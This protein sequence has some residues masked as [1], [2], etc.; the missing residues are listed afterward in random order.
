MKR[1]AIVGYSYRMPGS[2]RK[3]FWSQLLANKDLV[4]QVEPSRWSQETFLHPDKKHPGS[5][6]TFAAGSI[7]EVYGF[8]AGFFGLSPR[9]VNQMDPQQRLLLEMTWEAMESSGTPPSRMRGSDCGVY[10]GLASIDHAF[11]YTDDLNSVGANTATGGAASIAANR[12]SYLFDLHGPSMII[13]TACSSSM[14]AFHQAC[15]AIRSGEISSALTGGISLH[16]HPYGFLIFSKATMLSPNGRCKAFDASGDG[17]VRSE[18]GGVF[19]LKDYDLALE[20]GDPILAIVADTAVNTDG[21]KSGL[22]IPAAEAQERL[23]EQIYQRAG[24][25]PNRISYLEA[26]GTGTPVGDPIETRALGR[27]LAQKRN[28][29]LPIGSVKSNVGH[30]ETASGVAGLVK[31]L[32]VIQHRQLPATIGVEQINPNIHHQDWNLDIVRENRELSREDELIVG[33]NSFG[34]G[35]ANAHVILQSPP[36]PQ[37]KP[38]PS[39]DMGGVRPLRISARSDAALRQMADDL[40]DYLQENPDTDYYNLAWT[41]WFKREHHQKGFIVL[42]SGTDQAIAQLHSYTEQ[43][44]ALHHLTGTRLS[45]AKGMVFVYSGNG[46]QWETMGKQLL[47]ESDTF[48]AS[49]QKVDQL[50]QQYGDFSILAELTGD[51]GKERFT[52]TEVAQPALFALQVGITEYLIDA[53]IIPVAVVGH[54]VGEVA[55]AWTSGALTLND[56][57]KVIYHRSRC[58]GYTAGSGQMTAVALPAEELQL[59]LSELNLD[60]VWLAGINSPKGLTVAGRIEQLDHLEEHLKVHGVRFKRLDLDYPFH[61]P[62]MD[63]IREDLLTSLADIQPAATN[64]P[65]YSSVTGSQLEGTALS[66]G[67]WWENIRQPVIF[68]QALQQLFALEHNVFV[69][70]GGHPVL[71]AYIKEGLRVQEQEGLTIPTLQRNLDGEQQLKHCVAQVLLSGVPA[72]ETFWFPVAGQYLSIPGYP[73]QHQ[74]YRLPVTQEALGNLDRHSEHPLLGYRP[75]HNPETWEQQLDT[76]K[77]P[78]LADHRVG[79]GSVFPGA[80]YIELALAAASSARPNTVLEVEELEILSPML[81][82]DRPTKVARFSLDSDQGHFSYA[83]RELVNGTDWTQHF[84]GRMTNENSGLSLIR[85]VPPIPDRSPD[86]TLAEHL[87]LAR[88]IG[89]DYGEAFQAVSHGWVEDQKVLCVFNLPEALYNSQQGMLLAPGILDSVFQQF[90]QLLKTQIAEQPGVAFVPTQVGRVQ[91]A[92]AAANQPLSHACLQLTRHSPHSLLADVEIYTAQGQVLAILEAVRFKAIPLR[93]RKSHTLSH[94]QQSWTPAPLRHQYHAPEFSLPDWIEEIHTG[95][96][97]TEKGSLYA[98]EVEPLLDTLAETQ[99]Q[100]WLNKYAPKL[101]ENPLLAQKPLFSQLFALAQERGLQPEPLNSIQETPSSNEIWTLL[102]QDYPGWFSLTHRLGRQGLQLQTH[103]PEDILKDALHLDQTVYSQL[104]SKILG[105]DGLSAL[106]TSVIAKVQQLEAELKPG[107]RL[108][109]AELMISQPLCAQRLS[110]HLNYDLVDLTL[111]TASSQADN[112]ARS[113]QEHHHLVE[114]VAIDTETGEIKQSIKPIQL[115]LAHLDFIDLDQALQILR[116]IK[117]QL[118]AGAKVLLIGHHP[119]YWLDQLL[120]TSPEWRSQ[121]GRIQQ[122]TAEHWLHY[123]QDLGFEETQIRS[124]YP[125]N[126]VSFLLAGSQPILTEKR[127]PNQT[128]WLVVENDE[129]S[130]HDQLV[131]LLNKLEDQGCHIQT[132]PASFLLAHLKILAEE[133]PQYPLQLLL[134]PVVSQIDEQ[135]PIPVQMQRCQQALALFKACEEHQIK[136]RCWVLTQEAQQSTGMNKPSEDMALWGFIRSLR[137]ESSRIDFRLLDLPDSWPT[138]ALVDDLLYPDDEDEL[139]L[140]QQGKRYALRLEK[141]KAASTQTNSESN[142]PLSLRFVIPGQLRNLQWQPVART[143]LKPKQVEVTVKATGLNFRD[144]MYALGMLSDEAIENGFSGPTLGLEF[145]GCITRVGSKVTAYQPGDRVVGF[146]PASFSTQLTADT[147]AI[148]RIPEALSYEAAATIPTTFFTVYYALKH[149]ANLQPGERILIHGAAG[150]VG[151]AAIQVARWMGAEIYATVGSEEKRDFL[152]LYGVEHIYDSRSL[153]FAED[154]LHSTPDAQGVDVVLNSLAGEAINQNLRLLKPFGRFLELGKRDFYEN[155][156]IGIRPFRNNLSYFGIDSDQLMKEKPELTQQLFREMMRLF[157]SNDF[158]PLPYTLF[159]ADQVVEAFRYMQ[160]ARQIGKV[161]INY[162]Q[163][164]HATMLQAE[165]NCEQPSFTPSEQASYLITGGLSGF[166][167]ATALWLAKK[168]AKHL[169]LISRSGQIKPEDQATF[170]LLM[171]QPVQI[172]QKACDIT[173]RESLAALMQVITQE[174]PPLK[175]VFHAATVFEDSLAVN[176]TERQLRNVLQPKILGAMHLHELTDN[177]DCFVLYSSATTLF[178]NP[179]QSNYVAANH[180]LEGFARWR[181][182]QG[183]AATCVAWGAIEDSGFL[184]RNQRLRDALQNRMGGTALATETALEQLGQQILKAEP[185]VGILELEWSALQRFLPTATSPRFR[186][187]AA[188]TDDHGQGEDIQ[189]QLQE[190]LQYEKTPVILA[191]IGQLLCNELSKILLIP[192]EKIETNRSVYDMG[193]D[194]LMGVELMAAVEERFGVQLPIMILSEAPTI[195]RLAQVILHKLA[196]EDENDTPRDGI[197]QAAAQHGVDL[198]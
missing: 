159:S 23:L 185:V 66:A 184:A 107:E 19:L 84:R 168:G 16:L 163:P 3:N 71:S 32:L 67:Y 20:Q 109:V 47:K 11:R 92:V 145:T 191:F 59:I 192:E 65:Y 165:I 95:F 81:L 64:L 134:P 49:V 75:A 183:L 166:G 155:T 121:S 74:Q 139:L 46:C 99:L 85:P 58:Q 33:V 133:N 44:D 78:W 100:E 149:L 24:I 51:N 180:W 7:G 98:R 91:Y 137:N 97:Q 135:N 37:Q 138:D 8:D 124:L 178:G 17:Y 126:C 153:T 156:R 41:T 43:P 190:M 194:S 73:W 176:L 103:D 55:A 182:Q 106:N 4:S 172:I 118:A 14:V 6:Y 140:T 115:L 148:T 18:G 21:S 62:L 93:I 129:N 125:H 120:L 177:L 56:A 90:I 15:N 110:K 158:Q 38:S 29:P 198:E 173:D 27:A 28:N 39:S 30:L 108:H 83:S 94:L 122:S 105:E 52:R 12:I 86:F 57:V 79:E 167:L 127:E 1:V 26:H 175:G 36:E 54:S 123:L 69:E 50:F 2:S 34:F 169:V 112:E 141:Q 181:H 116:S 72:V 87:E 197:Q 170:D 42:A 146:G 187:I 171:Q 61:S 101:T 162:P 193:F 143:E 88:S 114:R 70:V 80:G 13:D 60:Q 152:K 89:L 131:K 25:H 76:Q 31:A 147:N 102:V 53:G 161:V 104:L 45:T 164:P 132:T 10:L 113:L 111:L 179:G 40:A 128:L 142:N 186:G 35:G 157:E 188:G 144:V 22:T 9:E 195:D 174:L 130:R 119:S 196:G 154:I 160:Q 82:A 63:P 117:Q 48:R 68:Y 189:A 136:A 150:G 151:I 5:T 96:R 77:Y